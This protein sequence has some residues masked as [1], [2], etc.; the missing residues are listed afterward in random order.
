MGFLTRTPVD[1][2]PKQGLGARARSLYEGRFR[3]AE[4][5]ADKEIRLNENGMPILV[6]SQG[7]C[8][9]VRAVDG[10]LIEFDEPPHPHQ[11]PE[12]L[13]D[14]GDTEWALVDG[15]WRERWR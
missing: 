14:A 2:Q 5:P 10:T 7:E 9:G 13:W 1:A 4:D 12:E 11:W 15:R 6:T 3:R 8:I